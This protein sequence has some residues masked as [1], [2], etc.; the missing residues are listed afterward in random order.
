M[1]QSEA[2]KKKKAHEYYVNYRKKGLKKGRK[3]GKAKTKSKG[4]KKSAKKTSLVGLATG[5]LNEQG[6]MQ[7]ALAKEKLTSEMNSALGKAKT[8]EERDK[9]RQEYQNKAL[10]ELQKMKS[11]PSMAKAKT[12]KAS[13]GSSGSKSSGGGSK[14]SGG[15]SKSSGS[16]SKSSG[17]SSSSSKSST[18]SANSNTVAQMNKAIKQMKD[19]VSQLENKLLGDGLTSLSEEQKQTVKTTIANVMAEIRKKMSAIKNI[20]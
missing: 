1:A 11:D 10:S 5:G 7:W 4:K 12:T 17:S 6:A 13:K 15:S 14:S 18:S 16:S 19:V 8:Q 20:S 9:I 2:E 3:K